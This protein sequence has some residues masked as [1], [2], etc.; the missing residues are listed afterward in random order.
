MVTRALPLAPDQALADA[1]PAQ[2][3]IVQDLNGTNY[4]RVRDIIR[5]AIVSGAYE[6]GARLKIQDLTKRYGVSSNPVREALQQL[7]GEGFVVIHPNRGAV[8]RKI[9]EQV[10]R[11]IFDI[12]EALEG[13]L[14]GRAA[15][16]ATPAD[17]AR[18]TC[19]ENDMHAATR[20]GDMRLRHALNTDFHAK[21]FEIAGN[22]EATYILDRH[23]SLTRAI[24]AHFGYAPERPA[25]VHVEH[26]AIIAAM[27]AGDGAA[28]EAA[29]RKHVMNAAAD[30][31]RNI[32]TR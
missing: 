8:V 22:P 20:A 9:D 6:P 14:S 28:A 18:L 16:A 3:D 32:E 21:I 31:L 17:I 2:F 7:Q 30:L 29:A 4:G 12:R 11:H 23:R 5:D 26:L 19:I 1:E 10:L 25:E 15:V 27:A 13:M 24:R